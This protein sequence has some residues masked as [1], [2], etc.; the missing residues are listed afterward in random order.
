MSRKNGDFW[1][2]EI[3]FELDFSV[4]LLRPQHATLAV[5]QISSTPNSVDFLRLVDM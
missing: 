2:F 4:E 3:R 1:R 5:N